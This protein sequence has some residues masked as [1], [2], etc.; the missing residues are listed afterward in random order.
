[1][2]VDPPL[3][4]RLRLPPHRAVLPLG[5][6]ERLLGLDPAA[7]LAVE[8]LPA[9][10]AQMLDEL[11]RPVPT[12]QLVARAVRRGADRG[13]AEGL[14]AELVA[15]GAV[16]DAA[17][18]E[19]RER[20]RSAGTVLVHGAGPLAVG[21]LLGLAAAGVGAVHAVTSGTVQA[22]DLGTGYVD[23]DRGRSRALATADALARLRPGATTGPLPQRV[24]PDL[25]VL[26]DAS[27]PDPVLVA[28]LHAAGTAHLPVRVRDGTGVVGPL[29]LPGRT[30]CLG[31]LEL[32]RSAREPAW[33]AA[34]A[35]LTGVPGRAGQACVTAT[36][37]LACAQVLVA[38]DG[39]GAA[40]A[41]PT[42]EATLELD[43]DTGAIERRT[44]L[45]HPGCH[46]GSVPGGARHA[47]TTCADGRARDTIGVW[48]SPGAVP[49]P[50]PR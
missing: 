42:L 19:R 10:L 40:P 12:A 5:P 44:W 11:T 2:T 45:P 8:H 50:L 21:V 28:E 25:V 32:E 22:P 33:P 36:V 14:L 38:L 27:T 13:A 3:P 7:A 41:P 46:C 39:P 4:A 31:C 6:G 47:P 48:T 29:V 26:A 18:E 35:R 37:G 24:E 49:V 43:V 9:P 34:A 17:D 1:M 15:A 23:A 16:V 30:A 20:R